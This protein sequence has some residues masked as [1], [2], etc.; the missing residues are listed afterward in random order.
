MRSTAQL[1][2]LSAVIVAAACSANPDLPPCA[3]D[4]AGLTL[5]DGFCALV[6]ADV[7]IG[8]SVATVRHLA[9]AAN[10]DVFAALNSGGFV[11]LRDSDGDGA[12]D[13]QRHYDG[14]RATGIALYNGYLYFAPDDSIVRYPWPEGALEPSGKPELVAGALHR[15]GRWHSAKG[16]AIGPDGSLFVNI[17]VPSNVCMEQPRGQGQ[18]G[19]DPCPLLEVSGGIW[20]FDANETGQTQAADGEHFTTGMRNTF[21]LTIHPETGSLFGVQHGRDALAGYWPDLYTTQESAEKPAEE[22]MH[23]ER[24][25]DY[26][27][28]YCYYDRQLHK[29][30]LAPE[31]G[32]DGKKQGRCADKTLPVTSF[33]GHWAPE[34]VRFYFG[35]QFPAEYRGGAFVSFH[36][37]WNRAPEPQAG[38]NVA[39]VP[40]N[41]DEPAGDFT[42][43]ADGFAGADVSPGGALHRP[44]GLA[45][46]PDGSLYVGD[47][48]G[49]RVYRIVYAGDR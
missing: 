17:G 10:G 39:F 26:G 14:D 21:A 15:E 27:W 25:Q 38:Y 43:F 47:D 20:R 11:V 2:V 16:F 7:K 30:V 49:G 36:G 37:S 5:P 41:G 24:G 40:F 6:V 12:A 3:P 32:G 19:I 13:V 34:A 1:C 46:G 35:D 28:P 42:V 29:K 45:I 48:R 33:P 23:L 22:F 9:V 18:H 44:T 31:Y 8:D 4:N